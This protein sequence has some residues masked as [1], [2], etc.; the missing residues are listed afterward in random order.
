MTLRWS[1]NTVQSDEV[2]LPARPKRQGLTSTD[3]DECES[4]RRPS[5]CDSICDKRN[6]ISTA[7]DWDERSRHGCGTRL[8]LRQRPE[9]GAATAGCYI[10]GVRRC[11]YNDYGCGRKSTVRP[12]AATEYFDEC[13]T[14][15]DAANSTS[16]TGA[17]TGYNY[18]AEHLQNTKVRKPQTANM[19][20]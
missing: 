11:G 6:Y 19:S 20:K 10:G 7:T 3:C 18:T 15:K 9:V 1:E 8:R 17:E 14:A 5:G 2:S 16:A 12:T 13:T 4:E